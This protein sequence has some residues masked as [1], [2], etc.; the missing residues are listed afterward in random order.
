VAT[1]QLLLS[2][3][4]G[5]PSCLLMGVLPHNLLHMLRQFYLVEEE[6]KQSME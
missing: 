2:P 1:L 5:Q 3:I 6:V 4:R